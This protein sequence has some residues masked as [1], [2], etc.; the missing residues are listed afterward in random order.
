MP[1]VMI[2]QNLKESM[3]K[4]SVYRHYFLKHLNCKAHA[5]KFDFPLRCFFILSELEIT[6]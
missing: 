4:Q 6:M 1:I 5:M 3:T 2:L